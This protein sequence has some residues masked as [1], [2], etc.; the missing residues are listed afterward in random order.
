MKIKRHCF[1]MILAAF[2]A[3]VIVQPAFSTYSRVITIGADLDRSQKTM[4]AAE[5]GVNLAEASVPV[6]DVTNAEERKYLKGLIPDN[7]IGNRAISSAMVEMLPVEQGIRVETKN[8]TWVTTNMYANALVTAGVKDARVTVA[9]PFPVS[10]TAALTGV[11]K[12]V[13]YATGKSLGDQAKKVANEELV[14]TGKLGREIGKDKAAKLI[15]LVKE[16]VAAEKTEDPQ[17]IRQIVINVARDLNITLTDSQIDEVVALMQKIGK[18]NIN[19]NN[20][21]GQLSH[22]K[23]EAEST[24]KKQPEIKSL[25]Q[26]LL[27]TLNRLIE[28]V[29]SLILGQG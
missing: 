14:K 20:I 7:V 27:D 18:L 3:L 19:V 12:A 24:I 11:F 6:L 5:F 25:L 28:Q 13:E 16:R 2:M 4:T 23:S 17:Q 8:I 21:T 29:R 9:A 22:W 1:M 26:R 15:M 10:G